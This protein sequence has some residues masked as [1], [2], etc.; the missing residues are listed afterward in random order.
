MELYT[1]QHSDVLHA[2]ERDGLFRPDPVVCW[3]NEDKGPAFRICYRWMI[4]RLYENCGLPMGISESEFASMRAVDDAAFRCGWSM[5]Q[6]KDGEDRYPHLEMADPSIMPHPIWAFQKVYGKPHGRPD[7]RSWTTDE[8]EDVVR[9]RLEIPEERL[10]FSDLD[11]WH[12]PLNLGFL[13]IGKDWEEKVDA[14]DEKCHA[15]GLSSKN[16]LFGEKV[17]RILAPSENAEIASLQEEMMES[18]RECLVSPSDLGSA[19][20]PVPFG[21]R[22]WIKRETQCVFWEIREEDVK[23]VEEFRTRARAR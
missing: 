8:P 3:D 14:F 15:A 17:G 2:V 1:I 13:A 7:M 6:P 16:D 23:G 19:D 5:V 20:D 22:E 10:L 12:L 11:E 4:D 9:I 21:E 18:W